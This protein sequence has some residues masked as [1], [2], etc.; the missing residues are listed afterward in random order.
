V[1]RNSQAK[2]QMQKR[3]LLDAI[4]KYGVRHGAD[5]A[6]VYSRYAL[7]DLNDQAQINRSAMH[8]GASDSLLSADVINHFVRAARD[9]AQLINL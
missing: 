4:Y 3:V 1:K 5:A 8:L 2:I 6:G 7:E 9:F